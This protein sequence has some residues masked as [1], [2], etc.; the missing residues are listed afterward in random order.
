MQMLDPCLQVTK[1]FKTKRA[2]YGRKPRPLLSLGPCV[3]AQVTCPWDPPCPY[4][5]PLLVKRSA[6][7]GFRLA[8]ARHTCSISSFSFLVFL[9]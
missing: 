4:P 3:A 7:G 2:E 1:N 8:L 9:S 5:T 6:A